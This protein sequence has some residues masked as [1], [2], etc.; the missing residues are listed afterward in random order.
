[1]FKDI[2]KK[3]EEKATEVKEATSN[4]GN[5]VL[6]K[7]KAA[8]DS[9][10]NLATDA[11]KTAAGAAS[12][13]GKIAKGAVDSVVISIATKIIVSSMKNAGKK[14]SSYIS[15]DTKYQGFAD[16]TWELLP[17]PVRLIGKDNLGFN[18]TM[19]LLRNSVFGKDEDELKVDQKDEG[20]IKKTI[21]SMFK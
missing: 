14:G 15:N 10:T 4:M 8:K 17:L 2:K 11:V 6:D 16:R 19:F 18:S 5:T 20:L 12:S 3:A 1:M 7:A 13:A 9:A 21:Q